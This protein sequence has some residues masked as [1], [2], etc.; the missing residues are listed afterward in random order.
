MVGNEWEMVGVCPTYV[1]RSG[2]FP[3]GAFFFFTSA[4]FHKK[5]IFCAF[6]IKAPFS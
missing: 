5:V 2:A 3:A 6:M 1:L 4:P